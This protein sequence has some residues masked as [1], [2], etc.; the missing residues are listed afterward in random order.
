MHPDPPTLSFSE[1]F[2]SLLSLL[3]V[4]LNSSYATIWCASSVLYA[5]ALRQLF[6]AFVPY[7][8]CISTFV[9]GTQFI[10][11]LVKWFLLRTRRP[12]SFSKLRRR[13]W[14]RLV[15]AAL[16]HGMGTTIAFDYAAKSGPMTTCV[17]LKLLPYPFLL[18]SVP[19]WLGT[20]AS[21]TSI[22]QLVMGLAAN[23]CF[24]ARSRVRISNHCFQGSQNVFDVTCALSFLLALPLSLSLV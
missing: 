22:I 24:A 8:L 14:H 9:L 13:H 6:Q 17:L 19:I 3:L 15:L 18:S 10:Y 20:A 2:T 5:V 23:L 21:I 4:F 12:P 16:S 1:L 11:S 7:P